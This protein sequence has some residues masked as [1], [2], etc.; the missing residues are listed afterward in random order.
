MPQE[1]NLIVSV[2]PQG[3]IAV[4]GKVPWKKIEDLK[5]FR[6]ITSGSTLIMGRKTWD[7]M[8]QRH[9]PGRRSIIISRTQ[10]MGVRSAKS[11]E[12]ALSM[13]GNFGWDNT[14]PSCTTWKNPSIWV[15]GGSEMYNL[16]LPLA[17][18]I[19]LTVVFEDVP[20]GEKRYFRSY[21]TSGIEGFKLLST[22]FNSA[23]LTLTHLRFKRI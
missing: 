14:G 18:L 2:N 4:D 15:I 21:S 5:R 16:F 9:L 17:T 11:V 12:E 8:G 6:D 13:A 3:V 19:D 10:Q 22:S 23:D 1:I 20:E 7:S